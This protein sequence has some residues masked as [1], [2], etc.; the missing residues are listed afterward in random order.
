MKK[1]TAAVPFQFAID[2]L[3]ALNPIVKPMF[4]CHA[5]YIGNKIVLI[6]RNKKDEKL[7]NGVWIAT[8]LEHHQ[9]L[10]KDFPGMRSISVLGS[11]VT[12][13]QLLPLEADDFESSVIK[14]C[15]FILKNDVRIGKIPLPKKKVAGKK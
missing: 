14:A 11:S 10:K 15:D 12:G 7:D 6:L 4:G 9:S 5:V 13:W 8:T 3:Y 2:Y 1:P